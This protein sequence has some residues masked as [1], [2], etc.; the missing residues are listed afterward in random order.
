MSSYLQA[1]VYQ[2]PPI[3]DEEYLAYDDDVEQPFRIEYLQSTLEISPYSDGNYLLNPRTVTADGEWEAWFF[4]PWNLEPA[5]Y[6]SFWDLMREEY[7]N[8]LQLKEM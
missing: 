1:K 4:A 7:K 6:R 2:S 8:F 3:S 5:R